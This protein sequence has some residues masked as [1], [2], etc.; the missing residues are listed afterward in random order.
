MLAKVDTRIYQDFLSAKEPTVEVC[1]SIRM[2]D[3]YDLTV[4]FDI[5]TLLSILISRELYYTINNKDLKT[6]VTSGEAEKL[7]DYLGCQQY[8]KSRLNKLFDHKTI[9]ANN[10]IIVCLMQDFTKYLNVA[11]K[12]GNEIKV[13]MEKL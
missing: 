13:T 1:N 4:E 11:T 12:G 7:L 2:Y 8:E 3:D 5:Q 6:I 10:K 9:V